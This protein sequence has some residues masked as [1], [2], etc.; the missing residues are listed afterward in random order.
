MEEVMNNRRAE[1]CGIEDLTLQSSRM[2]GEQIPRTPRLTAPE[3]RGIKPQEALINAK[4]KLQDQISFWTSKVKEFEED[5]NTLDRNSKDFQCTARMQA[6]YKGRV[7]AAR[8]FDGI[9]GFNFDTKF[10]DM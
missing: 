1:L 2:R 10:F 6:E 4:A 7:Y 8:F 9:L 3:G 5:L